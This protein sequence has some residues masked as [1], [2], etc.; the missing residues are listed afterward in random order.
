MLKCFDDL[1]DLELHWGLEPNKHT[2]KIRSSTFPS[3]TIDFGLLNEAPLQLNFRGYIK[4]IVLFVLFAIVFDYFETF[5]L[6]K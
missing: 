4:L 3:L 6:S 5:A 2:C 1:V